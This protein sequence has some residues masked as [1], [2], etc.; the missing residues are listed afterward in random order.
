MSRHSHK[1]EI[2]ETQFNHSSRVFAVYWVC[3]QGRC[4]G[5]KTV[6]LK[7]VRK[8][9][10]DA[11]TDEDVHERKTDRKASQKYPTIQEQCLNPSL[12]ASQPM[13]ADDRRDLMSVL[14]LHS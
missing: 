3:T 7:P 11:P 1:W 6:A 5:T 4:T 2:E 9:S 13:D 14:G 12:L 8:P 10:K